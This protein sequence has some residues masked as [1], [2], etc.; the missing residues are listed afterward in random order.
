MVKKNVSKRTQNQVSNKKEV[1]KPLL[2]G[3]ITI[4]ALVALGSLLFFSDTFVGKAI[5]FQLEGTIT[6]NTAGIFLVDNTVTVD[7]EF[8]LIVQAKLPVD[9]ETVA[10]SFDLHLNG[11]DLSTECSSSVVSDLGWTDLLDISCA[12]GIISFDSA[13]FDP[14]NEKTG[15]FTIATIT[16][17]ESVTG[18][19][20]LTITKFDVY[21]VAQPPIDMILDTGIVSPTIIVESVAVPEPD[22]PEPGVECR[23]DTDCNDGL[24]CTTDVC[25]DETC[26]Y[27]LNANTCLIGGVCYTDQDVY[28]Q[29][30]LKMCDVARSQTSWS[31]NVAPSNIVLGDADGD[32][33]LNLADAILVARVSFGVPGYSL[34][35]SA[36]SDADC[37]GTVSLDDAILIARVSFGVPGFTINSCS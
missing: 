35:D 2:I 19:Y 29:D 7:D 15:L 13:T 33:T 36:N 14:L 26:T 17:Q 4:V 8:D 9:V 20:D 6:D 16:F 11:L 34:Q 3:I 18:E 28:P 10:V 30:P 32:G 27:P 23:A 24:S 22:V 12:D 31:G 21:N 25:T 5:S 37:S 1:N